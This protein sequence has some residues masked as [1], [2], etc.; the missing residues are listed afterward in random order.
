MGII[1]QQGEGDPAHFSIWVGFQRDPD[2]GKSAAP[3][4]AASWGA[5]QIWANGVNLCQHIEEGEQVLSAH[6]YLLPLMEWF[7]ENWDALFHEEKQPVSA[8]SAVAAATAV[9]HRFDSESD[10]EYD[11]RQRHEIFAARDG[12]IFPNIAFRRFRDQIEISWGPRNVAGSPPDLQF[13]ATNG[14]HRLSPELVVAPLH[15]ILAA[16]VGYLVRISS[17]ERIKF[18]QREVQR[19]TAASR[20]QKRLTWLAGLGANWSQMV[21]G[22]NS[23]TKSLSQ[24]ASEAYA[25]TFEPNPQHGQLVAV[26]SLAALMFGSASPSLSH[27]DVL[28]LAQEMLEGYNLNGESSALEKLR[29][30]LNIEEDWMQGPPWEQ[31]YCLAEMTLDALGDDTRKSSQD[32]LAHLGIRFKEIKLTDPGVRGVAFAGPEHTPTILVNADSYYNPKFDPIRNFS[33]LHELCHILFDR[34]R[35]QTLA[36]TSGAWAPVEIERRANAFAAYF[37][38]PPPKLKKAINSTD[39]PMGTKEWQSEVIHR[40]Q[41]NISRKA[42]INHCY[43]LRFIDIGQRESMLHQL[44]HE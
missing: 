31:G 1:W 14:V 7:V 32:L 42:L 39:K 9:Q 44:E 8:V 4:E 17:C 10:D 41:A 23:L 6:W 2:D 22:W 13:T 12:G 19:I 30:K 36:L 26:G 29:C 37:C 25:A 18:L 20:N 11:W 38:A 24:R 21:R 33:I 43:N 16:S 28:L 40:L 35:A 15:D 5:F 27:G 34:D 3:E